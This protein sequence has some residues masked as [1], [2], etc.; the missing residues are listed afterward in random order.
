VLDGTYFDTDK[1]PQTI[2]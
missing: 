1:Q 2:F